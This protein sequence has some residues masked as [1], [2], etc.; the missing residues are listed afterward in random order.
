MKVLL[1]AAFPTAQIEALRALGTQ[2]IEAAAAPRPEL[3]RLIADANILVT[4]R[5]AI[6]PELIAAGEALQLIVRTGTDVG[7]IAVEHA[8]A[9]G[10]FVC[11]SPFRDAAAIAE[12]TFGLIL[13]LDRGL[14]TH[15]EFVRN[16]RGI[17]PRIDAQ[18]LAG[19]SIGALGFGPVEQDILRRARAFDM[20]ASAWSTSQSAE[21]RSDLEVEFRDSPR[22][23]ARSV[24]IVSVYG[25]PGMGE[26]V[27]VDADF[28]QNMRDGA[29]LV[30]VGHPAIIDEE[31]VADAVKRK[32]L[33][34]AMDFY[35]PDTEEGPARVRQRM[36]EL[37]G[38]IVT[39]R[40]GSATFQA[41]ESI[42]AEI[43]R[44][45][46]HFLVTGEAQNCVNLLDRSNAAWQL[47]M[48]LRDTPGVMAA[49]MEV[50]R[51]EGI[52][53]E[54]INTRVFAGSKA[55]WCMISL[56]ERPSGDAIAAI[57]KIEGVL[58]LELR[59]VV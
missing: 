43:V 10:I 44:V 14:I 28:L 37:P 38:V 25:F 8:S 7:N 24:D 5:R 35:F 47:A 51:S 3:L 22:D 48:R 34:V 54:E 30:H 40:L 2:V 13:A 32:Q 39:K 9:Q 6:N 53:A 19:R 21:A 11:R 31:A 46:R 49:I 55:A 41:Q 16:E 56:A 42:A 58:H 52:N 26:D 36:R 20:R 57:R 4:D 18:G 17:P 1:A 50:V 59:A 12:L 33:R 15:A 45:I 23:L 27:L 29:Y